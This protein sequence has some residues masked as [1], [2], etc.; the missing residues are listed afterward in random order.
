MSAADASDSGARQSAREVWLAPAKINLW[1]AVGGLR[2]DG[3]HELDTGFQAI[4]LADRIEIAR[5][6]AGVQVACTVHGEFAPGVPA[7]EDNL[8][9]RAALL[10]AARTG[11][12]L[13]VS[14]AVEKRIPAGAG[15]GGA[16]SGAGAGQLARG[17]GGAGPGPGHTGGGGSSCGPEWASP[18]GRP[19]N[20]STPLRPQKVARCRR[21]AGRVAET[22]SSPS[23]RPTVGKPAADSN[24]SPRVSRGRCG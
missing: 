18:R 11:H 10:L 17:R 8:A 13:R 1:L 5:A 7:G 9:A 21:W 2:N 15:V 12:D 6:P 24:S 23:W 14:I 3:M 20:G 4:D 22:T 19:M 16:A